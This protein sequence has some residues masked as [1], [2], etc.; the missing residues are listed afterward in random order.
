MNHCPVPLTQTFP[1]LKHAP[2]HDSAVE[3]AARGEERQPTHGS[4]A[5]TP[6]SQHSSPCDG[7]SWIFGVQA[8]GPRPASPGLSFEGSNKRPTL[9]CYG[10]CSLRRA[11]GMTGLP[12]TQETPRNPLAIAPVGRSAVTGQISSRR[13]PGEAPSWHTGEASPLSAHTGSRATHAR[14]PSCESVVQQCRSE[15]TSLA[16]T[17]TAMNVRQL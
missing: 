10:R 13:K 3:P 6:I 14:R 11:A 16:A 4:S 15:Q 5:K 9:Q 1:D 7:L 8:Q 2:G 12:Q 17:A